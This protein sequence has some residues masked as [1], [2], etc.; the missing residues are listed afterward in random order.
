L[1]RVFQDARRD[2]HEVLPSIDDGDIE[3][4]LAVVEYGEDIYEF[5]G[6][7]EVCLSVND[8]NFL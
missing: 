7:I 1:V 3:N 5:Y 8:C 6:T 2:F 4:K